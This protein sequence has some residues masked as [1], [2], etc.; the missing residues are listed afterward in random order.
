MNRNL[1]IDAIVR[2]TMVLIAQLATTAGVRTPLVQVTNQVFLDL[3]HELQSAGVGHKIIADMFG[4]ALR[5]YH[6]RVRR[7]SESRTDRGHT[8]WEAVLHFIRSHES[9]SR[10]EILKR[11]GRDDALVVRSAL[12]DLVD[13]GLVFRTGRGDRTTFRAAD[14]KQAAHILGDDPELAAMFVWVA[15]HR[16]SPCTQAELEQ[17]V[18]VAGLDLKSVLDRL[19]EDGRI[20]RE[21]SGGKVIYACDSCVIPFESDAGWEGAVFDHFQAMVTA[22]GAK[23]HQTTRARLDDQVGGSTYAFDLSPNHPHHKEVFGLLEEVRQRATALREKVEA[24][25]ATQPSPP[26]GQQAQQQRVTFYVGQSVPIVDG[27]GDN[28]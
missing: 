5:T 4:M 25:N 11:F 9:V 19:V 20:R 27:E 22:I 6:D 16:A 24:Y 3:V 26:P 14:P 23:L 18:S 13:N 1:L 2:Q 21:E 15:V 8:L 28:E 12:A 17:A 10:A 7:L